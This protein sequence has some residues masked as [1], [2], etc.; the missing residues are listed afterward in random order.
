MGALA[1]GVAVVV[2]AVVV[3]AIVSWLLQRRR[4]VLA[5]EGAHVVVTGGSEGLGLA[6]CEQLAARGAHVTVVA[7]NAAK[8]AAACR[9]IEQCRKRESQRVAAVAQRVAAHG[10][11]RLA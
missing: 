1:Y 2:V 4:R 5:L 9:A 11:G 8:L 6:L 10:P 3:S 7:R